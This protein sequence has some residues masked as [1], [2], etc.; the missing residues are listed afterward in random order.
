MAVPEEVREAAR[1]DGAS[2]LAGLVYYDPDDQGN[3][4][5]GMYFSDNWRILTLQ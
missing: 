1:L 2:G 4:A 5:H 3:T